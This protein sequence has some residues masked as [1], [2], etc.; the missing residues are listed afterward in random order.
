MALGIN[1]NVA[2]INAQNQLSKSQSQNDQALERLSSG[3][4]INSAKD[5]AAGL[6]ISTRFESQI[7]GLNVASRNANDGISL[8]QTAEGAL[9]EVTNNL[10][11][12]RDLSVQAANATNSES[13]R[14][15]LNDEVQQRIEE[16]DRISSETSFNGLNVLDGS[17]NQQDFQV[18]A[19]VGQTIGVDLSQGTRADQIGQI[20]SQDLAVDGSTAIDAPG[21]TNELSIATGDGDFVQI[22]ASEEVTNDDGDSLGRDAGS[23]FAVAASINEAE[24]EGL[25]VQTSNEQVFEGVTSNDGASG[26]LTINDTE[27]FNADASSAT[28]SAFTQEIA[29][30][31]NASSAQTGVTAEFDSDTDTLTLN[32][33]DGRNINFGSNAGAFELNTDGSTQIGNGDSLSGEVSLSSSEDIS[34]AGAGTGAVF[35]DFSGSSA[36]ITA[37]D[38]EGGLSSADISS[39]DGANDAIFRVDAA[40]DS[41]NSLRSEL[42]ATQ[43][44]FESTIA[45]IDSNVENLE[46]SNSRIKDADFAAESAKLA[47]SQ[48][49][50][51]A[52]ISVLSQANQRPQQ[53]LS[54]LQ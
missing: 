44:R 38:D 20:A 40:L 50:Q 53:V 48:V 31:I 37:A 22:G 16:I 10:Q 5:D 35:D 4:R 8:A 26:T 18:G 11:R 2:S 24:I 39:V 47:Q 42:G 52:G 34:F 15:A 32:A 41:V 7:G 51:Q 49:L 43:N 30:G 27:V 17:L 21:G 23:A 29:D 12:I 13:D 33:E 3:L 19:N 46:A 25:N 36:S 45:N 9:D 14:Q 54:L 1:T 6:A 28:G